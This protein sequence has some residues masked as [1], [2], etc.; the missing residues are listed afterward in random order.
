MTKA[1]EPIHTMATALDTTRHD[2]VLYNITPTDE[3]ISMIVYKYER[4]LCYV[5]S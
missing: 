4:L 1:I 5:Y 2:M 3:G